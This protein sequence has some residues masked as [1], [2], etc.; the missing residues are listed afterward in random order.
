MEKTE[1]RILLLHPSF[2]CGST[3]TFVGGANCAADPRS[4]ISSIWC[5]DGQTSIRIDQP[6]TLRVCVCD[7]SAALVRN[8]DGS[9][10]DI[11]GALDSQGAFAAG[12]NDARN[13]LL[14]PDSGALITVHGIGGGEEEE[15]GVVA[16]GDL[17]VSVGVFVFLVILVVLFVAV[18]LVYW[19]R[20]GGG[21]W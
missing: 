2:K 15:S 17:K 11:A 18:P 8:A 21:F 5:G 20:R 9:G 1:D 6:Q 10:F 4:D 13:Y 12:C 14:T 19:Y 7:G 3:K 16:L